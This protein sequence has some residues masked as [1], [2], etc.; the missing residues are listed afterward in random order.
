M[1]VLGWAIGCGVTGFVI[2]IM[3]SRLGYGR[4]L[5][6]GAMNA[7]SAPIIYLF[8]PEVASKTLEEVNLLFTSESLLVKKNMAAYHARLDAANGNVAVAARKLFD[9][10][11]GLEHNQEGHG[12]ESDSDKNLSDTVTVEKV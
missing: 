8:Y 7:V 1:T 9:E 4:F 12:G 5:F 2:P 3:L 10:V 6:F 11:D